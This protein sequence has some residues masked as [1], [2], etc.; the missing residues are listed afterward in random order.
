MAEAK[1]KSGLKHFEVERIGLPIK[2][3]E[4]SYYTICPKCGRKVVTEEFKEKGC[5]VCGYRIEG[6]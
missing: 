5:F 6:R 1:R 4:R 2:R 3:Q